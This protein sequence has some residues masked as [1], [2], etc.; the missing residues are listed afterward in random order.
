LTKI[1]PTYDRKTLNNFGYTAKIFDANQ[2][3]KKGSVI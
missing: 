1:E 2:E 3:E